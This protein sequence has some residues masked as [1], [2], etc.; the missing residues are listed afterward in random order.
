LSW[1]EALMA[2]H[3][4]KLADIEMIGGPTAPELRA[5]TSHSPDFTSVCWFGTLYCFSKGQQAQSMRCLWQAWEAG[6]H[7]L[8]QETI[9][10][11]IAA[12]GN[13]RFELRKVFRRRDV[14]GHYEQHP[15]WGSMI[16]SSSRGCY[17]LVAPSGQESACDPRS[18]PASLR[19]PRIP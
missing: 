14:D 15:G 8:S 6:G 11:M 18:T 19:T 3:V 17:R 12:D 9:A 16:Q 1:K 2:N 13:S 4:T 5:S 10:E 7:S